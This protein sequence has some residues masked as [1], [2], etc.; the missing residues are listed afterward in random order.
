MADSKPSMKMLQ[1]HVIPYVA[2]KC[3]ELG[4]ELLDE[5][6]EYILSTIETNYSRDANKCCFEMFRRWLQ[7]DTNAT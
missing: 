7:T 2:I 6:E 5:K 3:Y 4:A 1:R